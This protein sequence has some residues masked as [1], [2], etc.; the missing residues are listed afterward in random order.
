MR[1]IASAFRWMAAYTDEGVLAFIAVFLFFVATNTQTGW[2]FVV[3]ALIG[4]VLVV[5]WWS[6]RATLRG[7]TAEAVPPAPVYQGDRMRIQVRLHNPGKGVRWLLTA[8]LA[9][10]SSPAV[11]IPRLEPGQTRSVELK[12]ECPL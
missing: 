10:E 3:S 9:A 1:A 2:L 5:G 7:L 8:R 11:L 4:A 6:P 12:L